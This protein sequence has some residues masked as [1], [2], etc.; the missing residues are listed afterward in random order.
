[1]I[2]NNEKLVSVIVHKKN[3]SSAKLYAQQH[4]KMWSNNFVLQFL[5]IQIILIPT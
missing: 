1:M 4:K 5:P 2:L 3:K